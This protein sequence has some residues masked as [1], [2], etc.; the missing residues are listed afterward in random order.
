MNTVLEFTE[1]PAIETENYY[2]RGITIEDASKMFPFMSDRETMKYITPYPVKAVKEL[3]VTIL[4]SLENF[5]Q[6]KEIP[7]VIVNK[8]NNQ[9]IG[10]LRFHKLHTWHQKTEM[11]V[12]I[13]KDYQQTGVMTEI[14]PKILAFGF[15]TLGLNRIVGDIFAENEGSKKLMEKFG[16]HRDGILRETDFDGIRFYDT[17]VYSMLKS[18]Y[19][20]TDKKD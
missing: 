19:K 7:W 14:L 10:M 12:V 6:K 3:E 17:M 4:R 13:H 11:G 1:I 2:L 18:E 15:S 20:D 16:F 8:Q 9:V 5:K